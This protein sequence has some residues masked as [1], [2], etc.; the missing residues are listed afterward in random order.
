MPTNPL[1]DPDKILPTRELLSENAPGNLNV[2]KTRPEDAHWTP[3]PTNPQ[4]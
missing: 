3:Q 2:K 1:H 4:D